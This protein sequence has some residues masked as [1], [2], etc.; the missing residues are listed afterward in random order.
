ME[1]QDGIG[2]R[3]GKIMIWNYKKFIEIYNRISEE[4]GGGYY[5]Y[6]ED[7]NTP[8]LESWFKE[9]SQEGMSMEEFANR[10]FEEEQIHADDFLPKFMD[11]KP[12]AE[13]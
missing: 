5:P 13:G 11:W 7:D 8:F 10:R 1:K 2:S 12:D 3:Q 9:D 4:R 6:I